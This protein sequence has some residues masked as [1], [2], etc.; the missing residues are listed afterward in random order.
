MRA[1]DA[2]GLG[3][4]RRQ[5]DDPA[6]LAPR[7][8]GSTACVTRNTDFRLTASTSSQSCSVIWSKG[9]GRAIPAL[10]TRTATGPSAS[11]TCWTIPATSSAIDTS[12]WMAMAWPPVLPSRGRRL[13]VRRTGHVV[14]GQLGTRLRQRQGGGSADPPAAAGNQGDFP[15][16]RLSPD[17]SSVFTERLG[18]AVCKGFWRG[19]GPGGAGRH[20][21][22]PFPP[23]D[24]AAEVRLLG[25]A[26]RTIRFQSASPRDRPEPPWQPVGSV[27][28]R[29]RN[30]PSR[31]IMRRART[32][33]SAATLIRRV[34]HVQGCP[35]PSG[36]R[37]TTVV[38]V[39]AAILA[40]QGLGG[41]FRGDC[42]GKVDRRPRRARGPAD[43][44]P[45]RADRGGK[46]W[47]CSGDR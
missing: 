5:I 43:S 35:S 23:A 27:P 13:G 29:A 44:P 2:A 41:Q 25:M 47:P 36:S 45:P 10:F 34:R 31:T 17:Y 24:L 8:P 40:G 37:L 11:W 38:E 39:V 20:V 46:G 9:C 21:S 22:P 6:P 3:G 4:H 14:H 18:V 7:I 1:D 12:A 33:I 28:D 30:W 19:Q 32:R 26:L 16:E 42:A 15:V